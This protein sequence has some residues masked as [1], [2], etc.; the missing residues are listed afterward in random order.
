ME[1]KSTQEILKGIQQHDTLVLRHLYQEYYP[2]IRKLVISNNGSEEEAKDIFQ[3]TLMVIYEKLSSDSLSFQCSLKTY[4]YA[5]A[6]N[7]WLMTLRRK[8]RG[9]GMLKDAESTDDLGDKLIEDMTY[10]RRRMVFQEH[11]NKLGQDCQQILKAFFQGKSLKE[12][13]ESMKFSPAYAKKRK[14]ICQQRLISSIEQDILF[15]ELTEH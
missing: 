4:C 6:R 15:D 1:L 12:I 3:E 7:I 10:A 5:I 14:H 8:K 2:V 11:M 9:G 13:A